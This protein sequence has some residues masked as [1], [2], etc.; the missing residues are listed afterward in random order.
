MS[1]VVVVS[2]P[3]RAFSVLKA[4]VAVISNEQTNVVFQGPGMPNG[5][6]IPGFVYFII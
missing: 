4:V 5:P 6:N 3:Q 2:D 1:Y